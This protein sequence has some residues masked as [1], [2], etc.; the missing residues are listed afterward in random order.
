MGLLTRDQ[1][2]EED[3]LIAPIQM[4]TKSGGL[5]YLY[6]GPLLLPFETNSHRV[7]DAHSCS[8]CFQLELLSHQ[9]S[10]VE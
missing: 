4:R 6:T 9:P 2:T 5:H 1:F 10:L 7:T 3:F 8:G